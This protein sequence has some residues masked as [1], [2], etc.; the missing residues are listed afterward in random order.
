MGAL[1]SVAIEVAKK[2][3]FVDSDEEDDA[4]S[5][6][7]ST[8]HFIQSKKRQSN[9]RMIAQHLQKK[10]QAQGIIGKENSSK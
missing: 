4:D 7:Q 3:I 9:K 2:P 10:T 1:N 8:T 5:R 6:S